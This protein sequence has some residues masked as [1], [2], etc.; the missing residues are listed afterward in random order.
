[1]PIDKDKTYLA[2]K[3]YKS[4]YISP[5]GKIFMESD[6]E[7]LMGLWFERQPN[8]R[9]LKNHNTDDS[10]ELFQKT[11]DWLDHYFAGETVSADEIPCRLFGTEFQIKVWNAVKQIP[12]GKLMTYQKV[13][14]LIQ[15]H[16]LKVIG[17]TVGYNPI[18]LIIPDHR[19]VSAKGTFAGYTGGI[20]RQIDLLKI[21][22]IETWCHPPKVFLFEKHIV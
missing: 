21:E 20:K 1:M 22:G 18:S 11:K 14:D 3:K 10:Q 6:G 8:M 13:G 2:L 16:C 7:N 12:Y 9:V 15:K 4:E 5:I 19:I 17:V